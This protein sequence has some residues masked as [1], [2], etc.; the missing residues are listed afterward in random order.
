MGMKEISWKEFEQVE[1]RAGVVVKAE[2]FPEARRP[3]YKISVD[4]G[5][6]IGIK[7]TSAQFTDLYTKED[8]L[9][10]QVVGGV[11]FPIKQIGPVMSEFLLAGF[12]REDGAVVLAIPE[13]DVPLGAK[14]G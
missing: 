1:L 10:R 12:Y 2:D 5:A 13:R 4:F 9:G 8:L 7:R 14:L 6:E 3:A 11:N